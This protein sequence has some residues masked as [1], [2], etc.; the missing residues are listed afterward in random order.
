VK[1]AATLTKRFFVLADD[2]ETLDSEAP[3]EVFAA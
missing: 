1:I 3:A 2:L